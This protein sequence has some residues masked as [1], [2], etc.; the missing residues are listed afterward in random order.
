MRDVIVV[1][2][3][4]SGMAAGIGARE[5]VGRPSTTILDGGTPLATLLAT[6]GGR[7]NLANGRVA[8]GNLRQFYPRGASLLRRA[9][10][11]FGAAET[12]AWVESL[13]VPVVEEERGRIFPRSGRASDLREAL[14]GRARGIGAEVRGRVGVTSIRRSAGGFTLSTGA[15]EMEAGRIVLA[16]G[17]G[18][19]RGGG[20]GLEMARLL[21]HTLTPLQPSL[22]A[23]ALRGKRPAGLAGISLDDVGGVLQVDGQATGEARGGLL[24]THRGVSGP[25]VLDLSAWGARMLDGPG[26]ISLV[27]DLV[28]SLDA[29]E[30]DTILQSTF[31][32]HPRRSLA[33][34]LS[35][36][37]PRGV[38]DY[39]L[40]DA[41]VDGKAP[42]AE[43]SRGIR[44]RAVGLL[45][46]LRLG[47]AGRDGAGMT[48]AGGVDPAEVDPRSMAS[49]LVPGLFFAGEVL[50]VDAVSG[51][52]NLQAS[53]S[54]G[55][56]AG[57]AAAGQ[58]VAGGTPG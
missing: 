44:R 12:V 8:E 5:A 49:R 6:G 11:F 34:H 46:E 26:E 40:E 56:L 16:T 58:I 29:A 41:G 19:S 54:T 10:R 7:C 27:L 20:A 23:L 39:L 1:G 17:G 38:I 25:V 37:A 32:A 48:T 9:I 42:G 21:G 51:G 13:G 4:P 28:P 2:G 31:N 43:V 36:F 15:G 24:F 57:F 47:V 50:D 55:R 35:S 53:W 22:C 33:L 45:K 52:F 3:G 30:L 18:L 14:L